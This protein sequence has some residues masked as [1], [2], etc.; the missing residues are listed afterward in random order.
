MID[1]LSYIFVLS[2][3]AASGDPAAADA[4]PSLG[5]KTDGFERRS[6][7]LTTYLDRDA[8]KLWLALPPP[9]ASGLVGE[10]LYLEGLLTGLGSNPIGL[11]R[12]QLGRTRLVRL[13][14]VGR[15]VLIVEPNLDFRAITENP[16]ERLAVEQSFARSVLWASVVVVLR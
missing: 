1:T 4:L 7:L 15:R 10:Y 13:E 9:D 16:R 3:L 2:L 14:R 6:G 11:D 8:G 5:E 12:G